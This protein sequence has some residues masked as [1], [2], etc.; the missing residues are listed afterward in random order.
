MDELDK[1]KVKIG[2]AKAKVS[3]WYGKLKAKVSKN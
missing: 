3:D 2:E 1:A